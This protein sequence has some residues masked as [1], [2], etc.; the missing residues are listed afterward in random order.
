MCK[1]RHNYKRQSRW[2]SAPGHRCRHGHQPM[3]TATDGGSTHSSCRHTTTRSHCNTIPIWRPSFPCPCSTMQMLVSTGKKPIWNTIKKST[4]Y[5]PRISQ[6]QCVTQRIAALRTFSTIPPRYWSWDSK[7]RL[8]FT[9]HQITYWDLTKIGHLGLKPNRL[10][11][12]MT[13]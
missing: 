10:L 2:T 4:P 11:W 12:Y 9:P 3:E 8:N 7:A 1:V 13:K 5:E 6:H